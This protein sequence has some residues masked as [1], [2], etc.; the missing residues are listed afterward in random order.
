MNHYEE[1]VKNVIAIVDAVELQITD[2]PQIIYTGD[3]YR[4]SV[5]L[6]KVLKKIALSQLSSTDVAELRQASEYFIPQCIV[7]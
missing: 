3:F 4:Y 7:N 1:L 2:Y 5:I 6:G